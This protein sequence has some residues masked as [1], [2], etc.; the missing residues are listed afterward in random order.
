VT[1]DANV[2]CVRAVAIEE[3]TE[4]FPP[5]MGIRWESFDYTADLLSIVVGNRCSNGAKTKKPQAGGCTE[6]A[7]FVFTRLG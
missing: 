3:G 5:L 2:L 4:D 6:G 7:V 1:F